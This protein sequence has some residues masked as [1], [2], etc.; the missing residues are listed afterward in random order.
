MSKVNC[1]S[2]MQNW[3]E[4]TCEFGRMIVH[5]FHQKRQE[6]ESEQNRV[7]LDQVTISYDYFVEHAEENRQGDFTPFD[8][9][10]SSFKHF[11]QIGELIES[12]DTYKLNTEG[13]LYKFWVERF[14]Y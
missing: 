8:T 1:E 6:L 7:A 11:L 13:E 9:I 2:V 5:V 4:A 3:S 10:E 14:G 12:N